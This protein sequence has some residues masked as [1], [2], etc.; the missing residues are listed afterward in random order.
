MIDYHIHTRLC[1]H[2]EGEIHSYVEQAIKLGLKE[3]AFTDHIP[4]P[5]N[6]DIAHRMS[7]EEI[8]T[9]AGWVIKMQSLYPEIT[10]RFG[11]EADYYKGMED[12][13]ENILN[14]YDFDVVIMSVHFLHHWPQ[15]NW[16][17]N[18][19][20]PDKTTKEIYKDYLATIIQ[21]ISTGLFDVVGHIDILK[22]P[23]HSFTQLIPNQVDDLL[24]S[25]LNNKM[26]MEI[27]TSGFRKSAN[28]PYPGYDW[29]KMIKKNQIPLTTGSD[30]HAPGQVGLNFPNLYR[31]LNFEGIQT[32]S[33]YKKRKRTSISIKTLGKFE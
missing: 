16:V 6:F 3:I 4:L 8:D 2:A 33:C 10:I 17:F 28:E 26:A 29:L 15:G 27:N 18:F 24:K 19:N 12:F 5:D 14:S 11:I 25:I 31:R 21:G 20:F 30:A 7:Y 23:G 32:L 22:V 9:Y 13:V 1:K